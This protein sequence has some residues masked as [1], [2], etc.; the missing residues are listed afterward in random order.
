MRRTLKSPTMMNLGHRVAPSTV[1]VPARTSEG[2]QVSN[3]ASKRLPSQT[4]ADADQMADP[5]LCCEEI[6]ATLPPVITFHPQKN[7]Y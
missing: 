1:I 5:T 2:S 7:N 4:H 3:D 6:R